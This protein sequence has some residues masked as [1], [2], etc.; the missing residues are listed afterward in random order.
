M[1]DA[2]GHVLC[3]WPSLRYDCIKHRIR[4]PH[5]SDGEQNVH[6]FLLAGPTAFLKIAN[7]LQSACPLA[8]ALFTL[9]AV[10]FLRSSSR[11][12]FVQ[13]RARM[14][15]VDLHRQLQAPNQ[16]ARGLFFAYIGQRLPLLLVLMLGDN[17]HSLRLQIDFQLLGC[18]VT[19][20]GKDQFL[21]DSLTLTS[22]Y[23]NNSVS[24]LTSCRGRVLGLCL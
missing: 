3:V 2:Y 22:I 14:T 13:P 15:R 5:V 9:A 20:V 16:S 8:C 10:A 18:E 21:E 19:H 6:G 4:E 7:L 23:P 24:A 11:I 17:R 12:P 1:H